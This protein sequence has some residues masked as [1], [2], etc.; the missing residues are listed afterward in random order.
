MADVL[1]GEIA[2]A[3]KLPVT[4]YRDTEG[5]PD[6]EDYSMK[7]RTYRYLTKEPLYPFGYGLTYGDV[8]LGGV[9]CSSMSDSACCE[10][11][12][13]S[14]CCG[15]KSDGVCCESKEVERGSTVTL[16][17]DTLVLEALVSN[18]SERIQEEVVQV[19]IRADSAN[20]TPN[21]R[22]CGFVRI[23][24]APG[25]TRTVAV[26]VDKDAFTVIN[27]EGERITDSDTF[28]VSVGFGQPDERTKAL[29]G[30]ECFEFTVKR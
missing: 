8:Q 3:G 1:L 20:A 11:V 23:S 25:E 14:A 28:A 19:Y 24:L 18:R 5:L 7:G 4:F 15:S 22:L 30:K 12:S 6:F 21:S 16:S 10:S 27:D 26:P 17:G 29:T 9:C 13:D 2:P